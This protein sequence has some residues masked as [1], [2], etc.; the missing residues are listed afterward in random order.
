AEPADMGVVPRP[1]LGRAAHALGPVLG[2]R[3][4]SGG[5]VIEPDIVAQT[6]AGRLDRIAQRADWI[7]RANAHLDVDDVLGVEAG[8]GGRPDVVDGQGQ[9]PQ[10]A[11]QARADLGELFRPP[12]LRAQYLYLGHGFS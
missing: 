2:V 12:R 10:A 3:V 11:T 9:R 8:H 5:H 6:I 4:V 7:E 1:A